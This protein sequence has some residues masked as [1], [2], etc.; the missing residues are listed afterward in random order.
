MTYPKYEVEKKVENTLLELIDLC[1]SMTR[2][3]LNPEIA[4]TKLYEWEEYA[5]TLFTDK[6]PPKTVLCAL[7]ICTACEDISENV[8][9]NK[10][11]SEIWNNITMKAIE[12]HQD[13]LSRTRSIVE[14]G[15][16]STGYIN[17][18]EIHELY[19][20]GE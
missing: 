9:Y 10:D 1:M 14:K 11:C 8:D 4:K 20:L 17:I 19:K 12:N 15:P 6:N 18:D 5:N 3:D 13:I 7:A 16:K 2:G